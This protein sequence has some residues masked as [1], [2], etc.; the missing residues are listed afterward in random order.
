MRTK[1]QYIQGLTKMKR[2]I[3]FNGNLIDRTDEL[4]KACLNTIGATYDEAAKPENQ[5]LID[6]RLSSHG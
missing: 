5:G 2:N 1:E 6:R 4:Q 3:Y